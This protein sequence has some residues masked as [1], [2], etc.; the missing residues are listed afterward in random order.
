MRAFLKAALKTMNPSSGWERRPAHLNIAPAAPAKA[1][2]SISSQD[3]L[4]TTGKAGAPAPA[5]MCNYRL[6]CKFEMND[7]TYASLT[8]TEHIHPPD[9]PCLGRAMRMRTLFPIS[10]ER[11]QACSHLWHPDFQRWWCMQGWTPHA[12]GCPVAPCPGLQSS[13]RYW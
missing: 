10:V 12:C 4:L 5:Y 6:Q 1:D 7:C 8:V 9:F 2:K 11:S 3:T 13:S